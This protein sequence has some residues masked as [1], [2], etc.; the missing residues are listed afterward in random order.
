MKG[1]KIFARSAVRIPSVIEADRTDRQF[2]TQTAAEREAHI[3]YARLFGS[4]KKISGIEK[5]GALQLARIPAPFDI[6]GSAELR[7]ATSAL[8]RRLLRAAG[9]SPR[10]GCSP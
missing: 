1:A 6:L 3:V 10:A 4:R 7:R 2:V 5:Q 8:S 9:A